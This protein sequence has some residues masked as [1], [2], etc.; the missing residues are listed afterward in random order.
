MS[1]NKLN[2]EIV[3]SVEGLNKGLKKA[4]GYADFLSIGHVAIVAK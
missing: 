1:D 4:E 3:S 2:I